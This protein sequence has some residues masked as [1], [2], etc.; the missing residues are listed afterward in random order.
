[1]VIPQTVKQLPCRSWTRMCSC[2]LQYE[3][4]ASQTRLPAI[5]CSQIRRVLAWRA[6][7]EVLER[8]EAINGPSKLG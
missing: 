6:A 7:Q 3:P 8:L 4:P 2:F 5:T 1:M